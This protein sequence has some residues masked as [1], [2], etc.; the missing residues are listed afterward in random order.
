MMIMMMTT[1]NNNNRCLIIYIRV[2]LAGTVRKTE[3]VLGEDQFE[4][5]RWGGT[6][7]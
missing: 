6:G 2:Y 4:F 7:M 3:D 1:V 5:R